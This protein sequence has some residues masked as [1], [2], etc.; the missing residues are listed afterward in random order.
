MATAITFC[1]VLLQIHV[2]K[3]LRKTLR[4]IFK[5]IPVS[6]GHCSQ[7]LKKKPIR[8]KYEAVYR[9]L[10]AAAEEARKKTEAAAAAADHK[11]EKD[12]DT[13]F[14]PRPIL[15]R[16]YH[17]SNQPCPRS[18]MMAHRDL[19]HRTLTFRDEVLQRARDK[20][21]QAIT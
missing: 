20:I 19:I 14:I 11:E 7:K 8:R 5:S 2:G 18:L 1:F 15:K 17:V 12:Q 4:G 21:D 10:H 3:K 9:I 16:S 13:T 6:D